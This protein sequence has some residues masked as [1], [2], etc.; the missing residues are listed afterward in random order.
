MSFISKIPAIQQKLCVPWSRRLTESLQ[1][2]KNSDTG[3]KTTNSNGESD[4]NG[5]S[6]E[7]RSR[8]KLVASSSMD[9]SNNS[10]GAG[11]EEP[12]EEEVEDEEEDPNFIA[13][14]EK[15]NV[16]V[17]IDWPTFSPMFAR[18]LTIG[19]QELMDRV[20]ESLIGEHCIVMLLTKL[21]EYCDFRTGDRHIRKFLQ[22][23]LK[24]YSIKYSDDPTQWGYFRDGEICD[25]IELEFGE[26]ENEMSWV[27]RD[28]TQN[29]ET[30]TVVQKYLVESYY[31]PKWEGAIE[32]IMHK[33]IQLVVD[34]ESVDY[35]ATDFAKAVYTIYF[36]K[37]AFVLEEIFRAF[38][39]IASYEPDD[40]VDAIAFGIDK[41]RV[42]M[43]PGRDAS[44]KD[45]EVLTTK[46]R[47][48]S[49]VLCLEADEFAGTYRYRRLIPIIKFA[50]L[51]ETMHME[52]Y[53]TEVL[54]AAATL[55]NVVSGDLKHLNSLIGRTDLWVNP[56]PAEHKGF[57]VCMNYVDQF[58]KE[59]F[60]DWKMS[61]QKQKQQGE[62]TEDDDI[63]VE[64]VGASEQFVKGWHLIKFNKMNMAQE[65]LLVLTNK[66]YWTFKYD[67]KTSK[68]DEKHF[69][70]HDLLDFFTADIGPLVKTNKVAV[71]AIKIYTQERGKRDLFGR[72][73]KEVV[74]PEL[75]NDLPSEM[76]RSLNLSRHRIFSTTDAEAARL[77]G[78]FGGMALDD[79]MTAP[80]TGKRKRR[81]LQRVKKPKPERD[82]PST[83]G[84]YNAVLVPIGAILDV[85]DRKDL[86]TQIGWTIY[87]YACARQQSKGMEPFVVEKNMSH[88]KG[89]VFA[90]FHNHFQV[91]L[92]NKGDVA[93]NE[94]AMAMT[95]EKAVSPEECSPQQ[96]KIQGIGVLKDPNNK[97]KKSKHSRRVTF[98][99]EIEV[100]GTESEDLTEMTTDVDDLS[101]IVSEPPTPD[102]ASVVAAKL[103]QALRIPDVEAPP[104]AQ[105]QAEQP[106]EQNP[107]PP[108]TS[109]E[110]E[111]TGEGDDDSVDSDGVEL[112]A[113]SDV[114]FGVVRDAPELGHILPEIHAAA[115]TVVAENA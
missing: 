57:E 96:F 102:E 21:L 11:N 71:I 24:T 42:V 51:F 99:T 10:T 8:K 93:M 49:L 108:P 4:P 106:D 30:A 109:H 67:F 69:K 66:A 64:R 83:E 81:H 107:P 15:I 100:L 6:A 17:N 14:L 47:T 41:V 65:R 87:A 62:S 7:A 50:G 28:I 9:N 90:F 56:T 43:R 20:L 19:G 46:P 35:A 39:W 59:A 104:Q 110:N 76:R 89:G 48:L 58:Y 112:E 103:A 80:M 97:D 105:P 82:R 26:R 72:S 44:R 38:D 70:R 53:K 23:D 98:N 88:P 84:M 2:R 25:I 31:L 78:T 60:K 73:I 54:S 95:K 63:D 34:W 13:A 85:H 52:A 114:T 86:L 1:K 94:I 40:L 55:P 18:L 32:D 12:E 92:M 91:G 79:E 77:F 5:T 27:F 29:L 36:D 37:S 22:S 3:G 16:T 113:Q 101:Q 45:F 74:A 75:K 111:L 115:S 61:Q 68:F 33:R